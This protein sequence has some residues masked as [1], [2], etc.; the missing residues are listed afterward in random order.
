MLAAAGVSVACGGTDTAAEP[1]AAVRVEA[2]AIIDEPDSVYAAPAER[3]VLPSAR[4]YYRLT[5]HEWYARGEPLLHDGRAHHPAGLPVAAS[6]AE[7]ELAGEYERVDYYVR[8]HDESHA[9]YVPVFEGYWQSFR[10]AAGADSAAAP[11]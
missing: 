8:Q 11:N 2:P 7:M 9:L 6:L 5:D 4:I 1:A 3:A 10:A